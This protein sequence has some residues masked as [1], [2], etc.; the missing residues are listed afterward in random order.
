MGGIR[1][2]FKAF[3]K[4]KRKE[5]TNSEFDLNRPASA[6]ASPSYKNRRLPALLDLPRDGQFN[7]DAPLLPPF[8]SS[9]DRMGH[10]SSTTSLPRLNPSSHPLAVIQH[11][12][13]S[14]S[15]AERRA[16]AMQSE[17]PASRV[18]AKTKGKKGRSAVVPLVIETQKVNGNQDTSSPLGEEIDIPKAD[19]G[20]DAPN[21]GEKRPDSLTETQPGPPLIETVQTMNASSATKENEPPAKVASP[22]CTVRTSIESSR[23]NMYLQ[24]K[25]INDTNT[26]ITASATARETNLVNAVADGDDMPPTQAALRPG[27]KMLGV[28][29][30]LPVKTAPI[31]LCMSATSGPL[32]DF[33]TRW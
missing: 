20:I 11:Q 19:S 26:S 16:V 10:A 28:E 18:D 12:E 33:P 21:A 4:R 23:R 8:I 3:F 15:T 14:G 5:R 6:P 24:H 32:E 29:N 31:S 22:T 25:A 27:D 9:R 13:L 17:I 30:V 2:T 1:Q 7:G